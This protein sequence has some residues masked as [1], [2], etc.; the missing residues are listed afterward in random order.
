MAVVIAFQV[1]EHEA[2][3]PTFQPQPQKKKQLA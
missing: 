1:E 3:W 2:A